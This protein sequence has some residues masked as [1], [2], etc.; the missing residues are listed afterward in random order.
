[1]AVT[2]RQ[3]LTGLAGTGAAIA[4]GACSSGDHDVSLHPTTTQTSSAGAV[5]GGGDGTLVVVSLYGGNDGLDTVIPAADPVYRST[6]GE[7][8]R[9]EAEVLD[10]G[11]GMGF[12]PALTQLKREWDAQRVAV[13]QGVGFSDLDRSHF[14]CMD[15]WQSAGEADMSTG[16]LGRWLDHGPRDPFRAIS[17]GDSLPLLL[18]G[19]KATGSVI[20]VEETPLPNPTIAE[21]FATMSA[22]IEG[23]PLLVAAAQAGTD[24]LAVDKRVSTIRDAARSNDDDPV[25]PVGLA[26]QLALVASLIEGGLPTRVYSAQMGGFDTHADEKGTRDRL[27][28][29]LDAGVGP[30]LRRMADRPV[31]VLVYSEFG[32]RVAMNGSAGTDHGR[33]GPVLVCGSQVKAGFHGDTPSLTNLDEGDLRPG[34]DF[35]SVYGAVLEGVL[36]VDPSDVISNANRYP[37]LTNLF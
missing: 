27:M 16:W 14:H 11:E 24:M 33:A 19:A 6:R 28:V 36:G 9:T 10:L 20:P 22:G 32:R 26:A 31:T 30:F 13:V 4:L 23:P 18:Q 21:R 8:A 7:L 17:V 25:E 37:A 15:V 5:S 2:R 35:R 12:H 29:A 34:I 1:M 3:F